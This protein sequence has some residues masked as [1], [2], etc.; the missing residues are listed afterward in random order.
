MCNL[1]H[2]F[3]C[4]NAAEAERE[5]IIEA[6]QELLTYTKAK[7]RETTGETRAIRLMGTII[8]IEDAINL[9]ETL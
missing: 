8:G 5:L 6:L 9:I 1:D 7:L 2:T 4:D 3:D